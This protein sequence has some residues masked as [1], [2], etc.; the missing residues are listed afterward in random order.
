[1][2]LAEER[3]HKPPEGPQ[4]RFAAHRHVRRIQGL[5][6]YY[7]ERELEMLRRAAAD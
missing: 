6:E 2:L 4:D 3:S 1:M 5:P 7:I